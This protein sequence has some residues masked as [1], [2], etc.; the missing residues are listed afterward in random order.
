MTSEIGRAMCDSYN[1]KDGMT[2]DSG[3]NIQPARNEIR[4]TMVKN[5]QW[6]HVKEEV[7]LLQH[8]LLDQHHGQQL[9]R[10]LSSMLS[11]HQLIKTDFIVHFTNIIKSQW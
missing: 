1:D 2:F 6:I 7:V 3:T 8:I 11:S 9:A 10:L 4:W 5:Q